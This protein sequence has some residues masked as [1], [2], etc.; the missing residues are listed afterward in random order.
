MQDFGWGGRKVCSWWGNWGK[1][2]GADEERASVNE[3]GVDIG[4]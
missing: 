1:G 3:D 4:L 2:E